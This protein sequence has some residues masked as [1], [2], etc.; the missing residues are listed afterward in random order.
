MK[1]IEK[2]I[3]SSNKSFTSYR[4]TTP[5]LDES[6]HVHAEVELIYILEGSGLRFIGDDVQ[7]FKGGELALIGSKLPHLWRNSPD[8]YQ[9]L[10]LKSDVLVVQ[11]REDFLAAEACRK[12]LDMRQWV[13]VRHRAVI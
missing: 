4:S 13:S 12:I 10:G 11:F 1:L 2:K 3:I 6:W 5:C 7:A 9:N 8:Y